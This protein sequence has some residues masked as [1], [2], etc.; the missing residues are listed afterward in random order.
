MS[1]L[2]EQT[3]KLREKAKAFS[4]EF[5]AILKS[6]K[7]VVIAADGNE[8]FNIFSTMFFSGWRADWNTCWKKDYKAENYGN[9]ILV[10][11]K[12]IFN[13]KEN[14]YDLIQQDENYELKFNLVS[15]DFKED[16]YSIFFHGDFTS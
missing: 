10:I 13:Q 4:K 2:Q 7:P 5:S 15:D 12:P 14:G 6:D 16:E 11:T 1:K 8:I 3:E 9:H